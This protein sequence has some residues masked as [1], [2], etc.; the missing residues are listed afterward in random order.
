MWSLPDY[1]AALRPV[2]MASLSFAKAGKVL[3]LI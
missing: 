3:K 1:L 2:S